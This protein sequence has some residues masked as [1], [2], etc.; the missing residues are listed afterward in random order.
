MGKQFNTLVWKI[1]WHIGRATVPYFI[2]RDKIIRG[3][4]EYKNQNSV[5]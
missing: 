2:D 1:K 5:R 4:E 3:K